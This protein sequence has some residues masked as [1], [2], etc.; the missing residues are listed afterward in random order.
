MPINIDE[1]PLLSYRVYRLFHDIYIYLEGG[2][3][4]VLREFNL[5]NSQYRILA[6][7]DEVEG[8][9]LMTLSDRMFCA[10]STVTRLVDQMEAA[11]LVWR[12]VDSTDRRAQRVRLTAAGADLRKR[13]QQAH[14]SSLERR[15]DTLD[16]SEKEILYE[17]LKKI[18]DGLVTDY[19]ARNA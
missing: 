16:S 8:L 14:E 9:H 1:T 17:M 6:L 5:T 15:F 12:E 10:R 13:A 4:C 7:L 19:E 18:R 3:H 11:Q 2:D